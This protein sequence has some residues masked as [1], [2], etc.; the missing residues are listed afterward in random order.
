LRWLEYSKAKEFK[1]RSDNNFLLAIIFEKELCMKK[2]LITYEVLQ[3]LLMI[4]EI[5]D[6][7]LKVDKF[8]KGNLKDKRII[9]G[10]MVK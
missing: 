4:R 3:D 2:S 9:M 8:K 6:L 7:D 10:E 1:I 5:I